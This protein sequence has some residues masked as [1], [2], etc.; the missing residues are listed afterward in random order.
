M[1][2]TG[3]ILNFYYFRNSILGQAMWQVSQRFFRHGMWSYKEGAC[4]RRLRGGVGGVVGG[5][6]R[7]VVRGVVGG[8]V[9]HQLSAG[10]CLDQRSPCLALM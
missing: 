6:V 7:G 10:L 4:V 8:V 2:I 9:S 1:S 5:V 3:V